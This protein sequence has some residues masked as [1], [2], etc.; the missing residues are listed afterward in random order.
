[1]VFTFTVSHLKP[2]QIPISLPKT[3][4]REVFYFAVE[5]LNI[6]DVSGPVGIA[7]GQHVQ[8]DKL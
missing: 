8:V 7:V 1:M 3:S 4:H 6:V 2:C 5:L